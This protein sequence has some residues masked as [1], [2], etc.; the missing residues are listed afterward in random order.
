[1][2]AV[3]AAMVVK[4]IALAPTVKVPT[5]AAPRAAPVP[6]AM[7]VRSGLTLVVPV[8]CLENSLALSPR[9]MVF[10]MLMVWL[11]VLILLTGDVDLWG[12]WG[13]WGV[14]SKAFRIFC[15]R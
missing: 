1:M 9:M 14:G 12:G 13:G 5:V 7:A 6:V 15:F 2:G 10:S 3:A 4:P 8:I 11:S